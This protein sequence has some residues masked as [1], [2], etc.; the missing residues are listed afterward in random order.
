MFYTGATAYPFLPE[1][2]VVD[3]LS[4]AGFGVYRYEEGTLKTFY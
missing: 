4:D 2:A 3:S 1:P